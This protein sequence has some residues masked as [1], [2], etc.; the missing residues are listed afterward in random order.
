M[1]SYGFAF[2][3]IRVSNS[4]AGHHIESMDP[5]VDVLAGK[6]HWMRGERER[7]SKIHARAYWL[8]NYI[9]ACTVFEY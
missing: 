3:D 1:E 2:H 4:S 5:S 8:I 9:H 7:E 6:I